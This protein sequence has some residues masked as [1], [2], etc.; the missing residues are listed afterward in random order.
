MTPVEQVLEWA[1]GHVHQLGLD[2]TW[3]PSDR[4]SSG[5]YWKATDPRSTGSIRA[6]ATAALHFL[7]RFAG[8]N[9]QWASAAQRAYENLGEKQSMESGTRAIGDMIREWASLVRAGQIKPS[10]VEAIGV[11]EVAST[12]LL[13]QVRVLNA[14]NSTTP[15]API[16]LAGAALEIALRSAVGQLGLSIPGN[17]GINSYAKALRTANVLNAQDSKDVEQMAGLRNQAAHGEL[18]HLSRERAGM[19]EQQVNMFLRHLE[20]AIER[21][22]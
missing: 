5:G 22:S 21:S 6:R 12:D 19:L 17:P 14:D 10:Y 20:E 8:P 15:A 2:M 7:E 18:E 3:M 4:S 1:A 16:V 11:R 13:E 9:S